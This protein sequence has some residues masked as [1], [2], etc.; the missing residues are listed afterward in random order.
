MT[1]VAAVDCGTHSTRL[2]VR[3]ADRVLARLMTITRLGEGVD[4]SGRLSGAAMD[5]TLATLRRYREVIEGHDVERARVTAS[6]AV[7]DADN[8]GEL[9]HVIEDVVGV[10]P[11]LLSGAEE[12]RLAFAGATATLDPAAG[13]FLVAD[14]GGGSTE[15]VVGPLP[16]RP[17]EPPVARSI[18][19]GCV[20]LTEKYLQSD[21]PAPE[22]LSN[23]VG[24]VRDYLEEV[25][26]E[27]PEVREARRLIG[28]AG[29]VTT[30]AAVEIGLPSYDGERIHHFVL[31]RAAVED[32]FRT[33]ATEP[34]A[35]RVWNPG[36]ERERADVIVG[37]AV[38]L[39]TIMRH[40]GF[41][42]CLVSEHDILDG[43]AMSLLDG[44]T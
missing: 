23:A 36:L 32:V 26:R 3:D 6:S 12:G 42:E 37:G 17:A 5:R 15:L 31:T 27:V 29:T 24:L 30:M 41:E 35:D 44:R 16:G 7:R 43:I 4:A 28:L 21:P 39:V 10:R 40:L 13:P 8:R 22:E 20:R 18:D 38:I 1:V 25:V 9:L 19:V 2:L 11:H 34:L 33:L 14:I